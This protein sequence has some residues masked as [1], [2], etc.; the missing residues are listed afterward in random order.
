MLNSLKMD[1]VVDV[2]C[3]AN[4]VIKE[5]AFCTDYGF[6]ACFLLKPHFP[7]FSVSYLDQEQN[8]WLTNNL[9]QLSWITGD[10]EYRDLKNIIKIINQDGAHYSTKGLEKCK[11][12]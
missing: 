3:F 5:I 4:N 7:H 11:L 9:H 1:I 12:L 10:W 2:E 6:S 8:S